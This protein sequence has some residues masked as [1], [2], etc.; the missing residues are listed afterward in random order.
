VLTERGFTFV[1]EAQ[2]PRVGAFSAPFPHG[3]GPLERDRVQESELG[4]LR[5]SFE[6]RLEFDPGSSPVGQL[7]ERGDEMGPDFESGLVFGQQRPVNGDLVVRARLGSQG[8]GLPQPSVDVVRMQGEHFVERPVRVGHE[9]DREQGTPDPNPR[10]N[11]LWL[12]RRGLSV[13]PK[14]QGGYPPIEPGPRPSHDRVELLG[15][16]Q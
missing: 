7:D 5:R 3:P 14:G 1:R 8:W 10:G 4:V 11:E 9:S 12:E 6:E 16:G 13:E 2:E 15:A